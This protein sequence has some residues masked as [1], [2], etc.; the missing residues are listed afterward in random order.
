MRFPPGLSNTVDPAPPRSPKPA[1]IFAARRALDATQMGDLRSANLLAMIK[2]M[3]NSP[4][5]GINQAPP[6]KGTKADTAHQLH[7]KTRSAWRPVAGRGAEESDWRGR[8]EEEQEAM[9]EYAMRNCAGGDWAAPGVPRQLMPELLPQ[10]Y[11][12][13]SEAEEA[14]TGWAAWGL[15]KRA[16]LVCCA[17]PPE[18]RTMRCAGSGCSCPARYC[19]AAHQKEAWKHLGHDSSCGQPLPSPDSIRT[20]L[21]VALVGT[22]KEFGGLSAPIAAACLARCS[23]L[24][25]GNVAGRAA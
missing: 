11:P 20:A 9:L 22:L 18:V 4:A 1:A 2:A 19:S 16:C 6:R 14:E 10:D 3:G 17:S 7:Q 25:D 12:A 13:A 5:E 21:P 8:E 15:N 24:L 23:Q